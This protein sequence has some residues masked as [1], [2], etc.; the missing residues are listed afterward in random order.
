MTPSQQELDAALIC[1]PPTA[2]HA[3]HGATRYCRFAVVAVVV[4]AVFLVVGVV[5][6]FVDVATT[7]QKVCR[8]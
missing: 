5:S 1:C 2:Q 6:V 8:K 4:A 7:V 3:M